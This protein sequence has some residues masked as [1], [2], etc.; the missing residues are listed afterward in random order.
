MCNSKRVVNDR[1]N[2]EWR[3]PPSWIFIIVYFGQMF[4]FRCQ[5]STL[6]QNSVHLRQSAAELLLFVQKRCH[7]AF[8][9]CLIFGIPACKTSN[10]I[11]MPNFVQ[12]CAIVSELWA[13]DKIQNG[14]HCH[15]EFI[16]FVHFWSNGLHPVEAVYISA[17]FHSSTSI[18]DCSC[19]NP[20]WRPPPSWIIIL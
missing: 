1:W 8:Y 9:V 2:S 18:G 20:R 6:L 11:R 4:H 13:I 17:K 14:G 19:K 3:P 15:L 16:I 7:L 5:P 10:V 12:I